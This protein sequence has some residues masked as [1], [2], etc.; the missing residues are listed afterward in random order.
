MK[1]NLSLA[2][3][4]NLDDI[5][6]TSARSNSETTMQSFS[7]MEW[8][9]PVKKKKF[10]QKPRTMLFELFMQGEEWGKEV[11]PEPAHLMLRK[12]LGPDEYVTSQQIRSLFSRWSQMK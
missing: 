6:V 8:A 9:L 4:N 3:L 12:K 5:Q 11:S 10:S 1:C 2:S 7:T